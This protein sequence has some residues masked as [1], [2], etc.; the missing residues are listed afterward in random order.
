MG[1]ND[2]RTTRIYTH[3][4][5]KGANAVKSPYDPIGNV[6]TGISPSAFPACKENN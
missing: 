4:M 5:N 1:H 3:V 2:I 6:N